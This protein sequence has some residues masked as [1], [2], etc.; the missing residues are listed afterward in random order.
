MIRV[1]ISVQLLL[2]ANVMLEG[3]VQ[4][5]YSR[6]NGDNWVTIPWCSSEHP[7]LEPQRQ[8]QRPVDRQDMG[9]ERSLVSFSISLHD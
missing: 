9:Q 3:L 2:I 5:G 8:I 1:G 7:R 6:T 4:Q